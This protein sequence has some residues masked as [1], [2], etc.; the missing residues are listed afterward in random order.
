MEIS[1]EKIPSLIEGVAEIKNLE[2]LTW[3]LDKAL[4]AVPSRTKNPFEDLE[5]EKNENE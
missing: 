1:G 5:V 3:M 4:G 2:L